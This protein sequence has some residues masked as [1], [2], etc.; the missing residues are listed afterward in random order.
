M[1]DDPTTTTTTTTE[2][3]W[4]DGVD[5]ETIGYLQNRGLDKLDPK[6]AAL[7]AIEFHRGAE[8]L[9][10]VPS[11][12]V[13]RLPKDAT[14]AVGWDAVHK[15]LGRP[16][17]ADGYDVATV[18]EKLG[19]EFA[20]G[21]QQAAFKAG[22]TKEAAAALAAS[23]VAT[24]E[25]TAAD[26]TTQAAT[27]LALE[28]QA[29]KKDWGAAHDVNKTIAAGAAAKLGVTPEA[30]GALEGQVGYKAVMEMFHKIGT[31][32]GEDTFVRGGPQGGLMGPAQAK[33]RIAAL[34]RDDAWVASYLKGD[35]AK[36][37]EMTQLH[38]LA[39]GSS[40]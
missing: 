22:L 33:D 29:L 35:T 31:A 10:G 9:I 14:D 20:A 12:Q 13:L 32:M 36:I 17:S 2:K 26:E 23:Y 38:Q 37:A 34:K 1:A 21:F 40:E 28:Q 6:A 27:K 4:F 5:Q 25:K 24:A 19:D 18:K 39:A 15:K 11:D 16:D 3:P 7:K 30:L 8:K